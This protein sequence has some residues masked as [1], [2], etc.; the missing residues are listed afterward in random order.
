M[1]IQISAELRNRIIDAQRWQNMK[2]PGPATA[3]IGDINLT[4]K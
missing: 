1:I 3:Q 2:T 4:A